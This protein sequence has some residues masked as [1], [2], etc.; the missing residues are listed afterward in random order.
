MVQK[1]KEK[2]Y[3]GRVPA[4]GPAGYAG[5]PAHCIVFFYEKSNVSKIN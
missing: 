3:I 4:G 5:T 2:V 1:G